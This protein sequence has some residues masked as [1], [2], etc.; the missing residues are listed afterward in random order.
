MSYY[1]SFFIILEYLIK[2]V[3]LISIGIIFVNILNETGLIRKFEIISRPLSRI[4]GL[5]Y[6]SS[7]S[8]VS[9]AINSTAGK[10]ILAEYYREGKISQKEIV[11]SLLIGTFP[12]V[13]GESL[14]R[15]QF[16]TAIVLLGPVTGII[17][18]LLNL[19]SSFI[20]AAGAVI[21]SHMFVEKN[22]EP[23]G[24]KSIVRDA[25]SGLKKIN[26]VTLKAGVQKSLP[27]LKKII[28]ITAGAIMIFYLLSLAG[29]MDMIASIFGPVLNLIGL[30]GESTAALVAQFMHFS[31]GYA[32][33]GTLME[34]GVLNMEQ[35]LVT[36]V[37]GSMVVITIIYLKY[38]FPLYLSLFGKDGFII[39]CKTYAVSMLAKIITIVLVFVLF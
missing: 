20:Q 28:P 21:Y 18:T 32:I 1:V 31:A 12:T 30:P 34:T 33:V 23:V 11:P 9:M 6:A 37:M 27:R 8:I 36:L 4:S 25:D 35:A 3:V 38:S 15:V 5:S 13:L 22:T 17:Y 16:P 29:F 19:F 10:S 2:A 24:S 7:L 14:L 39:T 26:R